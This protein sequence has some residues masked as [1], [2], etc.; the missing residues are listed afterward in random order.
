MPIPRA[1][2]RF[3]KNVANHVTGI[4]AG[5]VPPL[6]VMNHKGRKSGKEYETP[7][8]AFRTQDGFA[9]I[10]TYGQDVDW[11]KNV[12]AAGRCELLYRRRWYALES[13]QLRPF[14]DV[15]DSL[16]CLIKAILRA[17]KP[18]DAL[19]LSDREEP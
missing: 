13:P 3:N 17:I 2:T 8:M 19:L 7:I 5:R 15:K 16:P 1:V 4:F 10:L 6:A 14:A 11:L 9:I 12:L 18:K